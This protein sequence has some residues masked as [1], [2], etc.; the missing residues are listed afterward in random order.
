MGK[1]ALTFPTH[2]S[3][4]S[5]SNSGFTKLCSNTQKHFTTKWLQNCCKTEVQMKPRQPNVFFI[6]PEI[7]AIRLLLPVAGHRL[8]IL[9][10]F[11]GLLGHIHCRMLGEPNNS[12]LSPES[13]PWWGQFDN[14]TSS[15]WHHNLNRFL[16][17]F[18]GIRNSTGSCSPLIATHIQV[19][20]EQ[21]AAA[22]TASSLHPGR[23]LALE[24]SK[25]Q[26]AAP[27][28][29]ALSSAS[30]T[31]SGQAGG[32]LAYRQQKASTR[33]GHFLLLISHSLHCVLL[34][35]S[36]IYLHF[37]FNKIVLLKLW[38]NRKTLSQYLHLEGTG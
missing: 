27:K 6:S 19:W 8:G 22:P 2:C 10:S 7:P 23:V 5:L 37:L 32:R 21:R 13:E 25:V 4:L 30:S 9:Q 28:P 26:G 18:L 33:L 14:L 24:H 36:C 34:C 31:G 16:R 17:V 11:F 20:D 1:R 38:M 12:Y 29:Q 15:I 35:L 3:L